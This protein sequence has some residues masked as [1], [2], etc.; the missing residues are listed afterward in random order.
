MRGAHFFIHACT[1]VLDTTPSLSLPLF[2]ARFHPHP[3][4][5]YI[6][7]AFWGIADA[8]WQTQTSS[9][10]GVVFSDNQESAFACWRLWQQLG[11]CFSFATTPLLCTYVNLWIGLALLALAAAGLA[12]VEIK[13]RKRKQWE[14]EQTTEK[15]QY[16]AASQRV[17][18]RDGD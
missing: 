2:R 18:L 4:L 15:V 10:V 16:E 6:I 9:M 5:S 8:I 13:M 1:P 12:V 11:F 7:G 14:L 17:A 3:H